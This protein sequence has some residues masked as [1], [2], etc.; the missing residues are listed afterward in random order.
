MLTELPAVGA[1][2]IVRP[3]KVTV[4]AELAAAAP[5]CNV[6][7][8][9]DMWVAADIAVAPLSKTEGD[10]P[11]TKKLDGYVRVI[12]APIASAPEDEVVNPKVAET[13]G[14]FTILFELGMEK[15]APVT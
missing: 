7:I 10:V 2:P 6:M 9:L 13:P 12:V 4:T 1:A 5:V 8:T 3:L 15:N 14:S 11:K